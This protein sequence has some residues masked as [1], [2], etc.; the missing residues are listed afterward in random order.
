MAKY[1]G[2][3][4]EGEDVPEDICSKVKKWSHLVE[5]E[6][7]GGNED[8]G[9]HATN[10]DDTLASEANDDAINYQHAPITA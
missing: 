4:L 9:K 5:D 10:I 2:T 8:Y 3:S 1:P 7:A 6:E